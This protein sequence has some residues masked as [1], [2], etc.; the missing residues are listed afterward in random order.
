MRLPCTKKNI[1]DEIKCR[2][3]TD[4]DIFISHPSVQEIIAK[5]GQ[6][7]RDI[8]SGL[9]VLKYT[10]CDGS[11][12]LIGSPDLKRVMYIKHEQGGKLIKEIFSPS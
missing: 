11:S 3:I 5:V 2:S 4:F 1:G 7:E 12:I 6:P 10:L 9:H 8:G